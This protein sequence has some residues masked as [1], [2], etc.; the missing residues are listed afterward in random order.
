M[1]RVGTG[2]IAT[3]LHE[4]ESEIL[5]SPLPFVVISLP[6]CNLH[7]CSL[8][9]GEQKYRPQRDLGHVHTYTFSCE[10]GDFSVRFRLPSKTGLKVETFENAALSCRWAKTETFE[11]GVDLKTHTCGLWT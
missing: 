1:Y 4:T 6:T 3:S 11:N 10:N 5:S 7:G 8:C 9:V 2:F